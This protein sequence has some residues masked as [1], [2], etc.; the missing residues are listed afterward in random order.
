ME[1]TKVKQVFDKLKNYCYFAKEDDY[2]TITEWDNGEGY[3]I[4]LSNKQ[5]IRVTCGELEA[6]NHL[7][8]CLDYH[9][10]NNE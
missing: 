8:K 10:F 4:D 2:I 5:I 9:K 3:D 7:I 6:I 1:F